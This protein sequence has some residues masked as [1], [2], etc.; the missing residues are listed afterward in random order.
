MYIFLDLKLS[1]D[2]D[3]MIDLTELNSN[4][5]SPVADSKENLIEVCWIYYDI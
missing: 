3:I 1:M 4:L 5:Y 2:K